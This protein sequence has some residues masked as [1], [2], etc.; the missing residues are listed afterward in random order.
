MTN[1][2]DFLVGNWTSK[3]RR[4]REVLAGSDDWYEFDGITRCWSVFDGSGNIDE[5]H[6]P[7]Q[8]YTG[9]TVRLFDPGTELWSIYWARND[10]GLALPPT[11]GRFDE[12]GVGRFYDD[13]DWHG[14]PIRV[15][16][17]WTVLSDDACRWEQ[18]FSTDAFSTDAFS[19]DQG[20]TW[21]TNWT[22][23]FTRVSAR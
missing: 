21:E 23:D 19:T 15:R 8:G 17:Q 10:T 3:Q 4:L 20:E 14:R 7:D 16:Y 5:V 22:A 18:A 9:L 12:D 1:N 6:F 13:E 2:F 11:V